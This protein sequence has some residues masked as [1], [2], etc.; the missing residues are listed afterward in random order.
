M[1]VLPGS[2][3]GHVVV[4]ENANG[5]WESDPGRPFEKSSEVALAVSADQPA[6]KKQQT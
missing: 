3:A 4:P 2:G 5:R 6:R 1:S